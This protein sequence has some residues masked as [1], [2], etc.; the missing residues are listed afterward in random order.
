MPFERSVRDK[1]IIVFG[2][3]QL[4]SFNFSREY[5]KLGRTPL[6]SEFHF[7]CNFWTPI[8]NVGGEFLFAHMAF[9]SGVMNLKA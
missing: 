8:A 7:V 4:G 2:S 3:P 6:F 1:F 9:C 5:E